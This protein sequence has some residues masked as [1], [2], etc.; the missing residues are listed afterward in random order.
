MVRRNQLVA[1]L[2]IAVLMGATVATTTMPGVRGTSSPTH[3]D[4]RSRRG[5]QEIRTPC[6]EYNSNTDSIRTVRCISLTYIHTSSKTCLYIPSYYHTCRIG[7]NSISI[8]VSVPYAPTPGSTYVSRYYHF[9]K[10]F[11]NQLNYRNHYR[12]SCY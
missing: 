12:N 4:I 6:D 8:V 9:Y 11:I 5:R 2:A 7:A 1:F 10:S 3:N